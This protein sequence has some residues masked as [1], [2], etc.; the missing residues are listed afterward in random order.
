MVERPYSVHRGDCDR[1]MYTLESETVEAVIT[2][3]PYGTASATKARSIGGK[4][5][6]AFNIAWDREMPTAWVEQAA[7]LL[8]PGGS[9]IA[10]ADTKRPGELWELMR[11][12]GL[13]PLRMLYWRKTNPPPNPRKNFQSAVEVAV[14][15]RKPGK[16]IHWGGGGA[17]QNIFDFPLAMGNDR[18]DHPTQK[19]LDL[20]RALCRVVCP[21]GGTILDPF[22]GSGTTGVAAMAE[23]MRSVL[24]EKDEDY[25]SI[26]VDRLERW[27][28]SDQIRQR[29]L[30]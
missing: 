10:F 6:E 8:K 11:W 18:T 4:V 23:G 25:H 30:I 3:P 15:A 19:N 9:I 5:V 29:K 14:F 7:R 21:V 27:R 17:T 2:D 16:I 22:A 26:M 28:D 13:K 1:I 24:I 12:A 20:M